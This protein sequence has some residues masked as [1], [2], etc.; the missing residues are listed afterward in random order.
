MRPWSDMVKI[1]DNMPEQCMNPEKS[2][3]SRARYNSGPGLIAS[4]VL[5]SPLIHIDVN[6]KEEHAVAIPLQFMLVMN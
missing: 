3:V 5:V 2:L 4:V 1:H 6:G